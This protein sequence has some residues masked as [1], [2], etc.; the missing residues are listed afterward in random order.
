MRRKNH[1]AGL[2]MDED[3]ATGRQ[4]HLLTPDMLIEVEETF[5]M[6]KGQND[7]ID[8]RLLPIALKAL[9]MAMSDLT[10]AAK[11]SDDIED[12]K[13]EKI[14]IHKFT[15]IVAECIKQPNWAA[16]EMAEA[17][18][19]FDKDRG[20]TVDHFELK[21]VFLNI[22]EPVQASEIEDQLREVDIDGDTAM[23]LSEWHKMIESTKGKD[24]IFDDSLYGSIEDRDDIQW[25][26]EKPN[27]NLKLLLP[28]F[29]KRVTMREVIRENS[30]VNSFYDI[31]DIDINN[32]QVK[33]E[34]FKDSVCYLVNVAS[35][36]GFTAAQ[37]KFFRHL[38]D[39]YGSCGLEVCTVLYCMYHSSSLMVYMVYIWYIW[40]I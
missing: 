18:S 21:E 33:F 6:V 3:T 31:V 14:D 12:Y 13:G 11:K 10:D 23:C 22:G 9:G 17:F 38:Q 16:N 37:Y 25:R 39:A 20:G 32:E 24:F 4:R 19:Y 27:P 1:L 7:L 40:C 15:E 28:E 8:Y 36:C 35:L 34:R 29:E 5:A 2:T 30:I 26:L